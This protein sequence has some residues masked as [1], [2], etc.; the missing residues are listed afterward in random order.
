[1]PW[2]LLTPW[3]VLLLSLGATLA[4]WWSGAIEREHLRARQ[5]ASRAQTLA[6]SLNER[7]VAYEQVM[8]GA[9]A[10][11]KVHGDPDPQQWSRYVSHLGLP[12]TLSGT[13]GLG[14]V[15]RI[16]A[17]ALPQHEAAMRVEYPDYKVWPAGQREF[18]YP[19]TRLH[20][21]LNDEARPPIGF[22]AGTDSERLATLMRA[23]ATGEPAYSGLVFLKT[24]GF[25][26]VQE[27]PEPA[28]IVYRAIPRGDDGAQGASRRAEAPAGFIVM[29]AMPP[30][31]YFTSGSLPRLP[32][33]ITLLTPRAMFF[34]DSISS[35]SDDG[36]WSIAAS[37]CAV[38]RRRRAG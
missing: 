16:Q 29:I 38:G 32:T 15:A 33:R 36:Q 7:L 31:V 18:Y 5:L 22:D 26:G 27:E 24:V 35:G 2:A 13:T 1:M 30:C 12:E 3:A 19:L 34:L 37:P 14:I 9:A 23:T 28:F 25:S 21:V 4:W 11:I 20:Q 8:H 10:L 6:A 17:G